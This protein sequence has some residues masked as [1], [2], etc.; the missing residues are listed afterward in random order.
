MVI[1][2]D[3]FRRLSLL[4]RTCDCRLR[5]YFRED[6]DGKT[7]DLLIMVDC[8]RVTEDNRSLLVRGYIGPFFR[9]QIWYRVQR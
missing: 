6:D 7:V 8:R 2:N 9:R 5:T 4:L 1:R 3:D